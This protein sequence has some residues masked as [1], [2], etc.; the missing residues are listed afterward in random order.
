MTMII[1]SIIS[2][3]IILF[4]LMLIVRNELVFRERNKMI[5]WIFSHK[6]WEEKIKLFDEYGYNEMVLKFWKPVKSFYKQY[7]K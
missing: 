4:L 5:D 7:L 2:I 6:N 3:I 1:S